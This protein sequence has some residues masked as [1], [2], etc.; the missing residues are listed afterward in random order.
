[1]QK[2]EIGRMIKIGQNSVRCIVNLNLGW[3]FHPGDEPKAWYKG[4]EDSSWRMVTLPHDWSVEFPFDRRNASGTGYLP[5]GTGVYRKHFSIPGEW[6]G[7]RVYITFNGVYNNGMFWCNS[8][9]LGKM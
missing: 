1:M 9:Y 5:G 2:E 7:K 6:K 8:Y 4:F 3:R